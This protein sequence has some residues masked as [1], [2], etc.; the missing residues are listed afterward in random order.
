M[1]K[2]NR[3]KIYENNTIV[4]SRTYNHITTNLLLTAFKYFNNKPIDLLEKVVLK[5]INKISE[6]A[7]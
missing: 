4:Q 5:V 2:Q 3:A 1:I 7:F 6:Y